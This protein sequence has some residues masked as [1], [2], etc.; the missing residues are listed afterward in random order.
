VPSFG[1]VRPLAS[2]GIDDVSACGDAIRA[3]ADGCSS[4][5]E[6]AQRIV[7]YLYDELGDDD[8]NRA[9]PLVRL[10]KTHP[11]G[12]L[13]PDLQEFAR[14]ALGAEPAADVRC[15]TLLATAG[16]REAWNDRRRSVGHK[17]IPLPSEELVL[18]LP[19]VAQLITQLG[20]ELEAVVRPRREHAVKLSQ[21]TYDVFHVE[22]AVG[23]PYLPAQD[24]FVV[25]N[26][27]RSALGFG[28]MLPS[29]DFYAAVLFSRVQVSRTAAE[30]LKILSLAV[31][32]PLF[33]FVL[34]STFA[35][36]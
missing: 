14:S 25:P 17:A 30:N 19:M 34:K 6:A 8:G 9:C 4:M 12:D 29:G 27:I 11:Y 2:F 7:R 18:R 22:E 5:E 13:P 35:D 24:D 26:G 28:G 23:S 16:E 32:V 36:A 3:A 10:Y 31:R 15:L 33:A 20:L 1:A 21:R